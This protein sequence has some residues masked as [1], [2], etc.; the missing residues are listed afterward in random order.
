MH[1]HYALESLRPGPPMA[2]TI[3]AFDGIHLGHQRL[4]QQVRAAAARLDGESAVLT[5]EPHPDRVL[6]PERE[7]LLLTTSAER[8]RLIEALGVDHLIV[9]PFDRKLARIPAETFMES[10]CAAMALR[11]LWVGPDAR[12]GAGGRGTAP[13]LRDLGLRLGYTVHEVERL[14]VAGQIVS[15]TTIRKALGAGRVDEAARLLGR[16][17]AIGGE[18]VHGDHRGATIG[19]PTANVAYAPDQLLP[20]D[21]VYACRVTLTDGRDEY[22][23]VTNVGLR[24]T[25]GS[26]R[27]TVEAYLLDWNGDLYGQTIRV[28]FLRRLRGEQKFSGIDALIAQIKAD[29]AA[30]RE[31]LAQ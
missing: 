4:I 23:A 25:F 10:V 24:P 20:A 9:L 1:V 13:V 14:Q 22:P 8:M 7:C 28:G 21:G 18:V 5:F 12:L 2:L 27:R 3:G 29:V 31:I 19:F 16:P 15:S 17:F 30:A 11:E 26:L 6:H